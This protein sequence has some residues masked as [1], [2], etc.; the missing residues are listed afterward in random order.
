[1]CLMLKK[2]LNTRKTLSARL[3]TTYNHSFSVSRNGSAWFSKTRARHEVRV[4]RGLDDGTISFKFANGWIQ[5]PDRSCVMDC[6]REVAATLH[7]SL[8]LPTLKIWKH[9]WLKSSSQQRDLARHPAKT[10]LT[11]TESSVASYSLKSD[12]GFPKVQQIL[13]TIRVFHTSETGNKNMLL[14]V[15]VYFCVPLFNHNCFKNKKMSDLI[16]QC[17]CIWFDSP[18]THRA[19]QKHCS[20]PKTN[21]FTSVDHCLA[22]LAAH[23]R[24]TA[25]YAQCKFG[26]TEADALQAITSVCKPDKRT[27]R[28]KCN[29]AREK[30]R[31]GRCK[32][33]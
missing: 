2:A 20:C 18:L 4:W 26:G 31:C 28:W 12:L 30:Q 10:F 32:K 9:S 14:L 29:C 13:F 1:M 24:N 15:S 22:V 6:R 23:Q 11:S 3:V 8:H 5:F 33:E 17:P 7:R 25:M 16:S 21:S 27:I 19:Y